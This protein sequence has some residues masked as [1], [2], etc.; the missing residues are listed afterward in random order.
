MEGWP[1]RQIR[2]SPLSVLAARSIVAFSSGR[3]TPSGGPEISP[4][5]GRAARVR[6]PD[7]GMGIYVLAHG[8]T[9]QQRRALERQLSL[10]GQLRGGLVVVDG[11]EVVLQRPTRHPVAQ[12]VA[13]HHSLAEVD[14][15][16][17]PGVHGLL[18]QG[19]RG[20]VVPGRPG[21]GG[22]HD[23]IEVLGAEQIAEPVGGGAGEAGMAAEV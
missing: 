3:S 13:L 7:G 17:D 20:R 19:P 4:Y 1:W 15:Q 2:G 8:P 9:A 11:L 21:D 10:S 23:K 22:A 6:R 12:P 5:R 18:V 16:P 14:A